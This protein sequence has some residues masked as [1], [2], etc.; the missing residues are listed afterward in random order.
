MTHVMTHVL[1][2]VCVC[3]LKGLLDLLKECKAPNV[4]TSHTS[5]WS[6]DEVLRAI[7]EH[8]LG[9]L[10]DAVHASPVLSMIGD[11]STVID[12]TGKL[13]TASG[14][15]LL[16]KKAQ[17][18]VVFVELTDLEGDAAA[19]NICNKM[20]DALQTR[21]CLTLSPSHRSWCDL[22]VTFGELHYTMHISCS[23]LSRAHT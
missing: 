3:S 23:H 22:M 4:R 13:A 14:L 6:R 16:D 17:L 2:A 20:I 21:C 11:E 5:S 1:T 8:D 18:N 10:R 7:R 9:E 19:N 15:Q 12:A